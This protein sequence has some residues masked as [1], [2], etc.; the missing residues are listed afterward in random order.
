MVSN[1][2]LSLTRLLLADGGDV[3]YLTIPLTRL[4]LADGG[5]GWYLDYPVN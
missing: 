4:L 2:S 3:C 1:W 5:D